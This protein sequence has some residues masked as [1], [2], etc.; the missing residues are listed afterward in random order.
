MEGPTSVSSL[1]HAATMVAAGVFLLARLFP[2][3][4]GVILA[5]IAITGIFT[6]FLAATV[7]IVQYDIKQV[8]AYSTISQLGF[9]M[10]GIGTGYCEGALDRTSTRLNSSH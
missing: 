2:L 8:L 1:I 7:A 10:L 5:V 3:F 9:M 6:A 4:P